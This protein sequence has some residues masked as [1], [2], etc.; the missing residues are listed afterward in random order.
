[1]ARFRAEIVSVEGQ[2]ALVVN[3]NPRFLQAPFLHKAP[4]ES[5]AAA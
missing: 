2:P 3:G 4:C 5:F 1:M